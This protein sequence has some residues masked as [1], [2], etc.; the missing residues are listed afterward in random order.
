M[1]I[2]EMA[3]KIN[4]MSVKSNEDA[5]QINE[6]GIKINEKQWMLKSNNDHSE[7]GGPKIGKKESS[8]KRKR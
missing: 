6:I 5:K 7:P 4:E 3:I 8:A 2:N 1:E